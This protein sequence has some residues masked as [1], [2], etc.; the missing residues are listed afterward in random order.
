MKIA[1]AFAIASAA[2]TLSEIFSR[3]DQR[4]EPTRSPPANN[5]HASDLSIDEIVKLRHQ[6]DRF[7]QRKHARSSAFPRSV[8][9]PFSIRRALEASL[10]ALVTNTRRTASSPP[11]A[12]KRQPAA[13]S[14]T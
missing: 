7:L 13:A 14:G 9:M 1:L 6:I 10:I 4:A 5:V 8:R 3:A 12:A 11:P 2:F